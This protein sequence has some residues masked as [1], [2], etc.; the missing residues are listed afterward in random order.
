MELPRPFPEAFPAVGCDQQLAP[1]ALP[2][3]ESI[4][5][6]HRHPSCLTRLSYVQLPWKVFTAYNPFSLQ[7]LKVTG[8]SLS[9]ASHQ[10]GLCHKHVQEVGVLIALLFARP[11]QLGCC[12]V[13]FWLPGRAELLPQQEESAHTGTGLQKKPSLDFVTL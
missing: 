6:F 7:N 4:H 10:A 2:P 9:P 13:T 8:T 1:M 12:W 11:P 3:A 5:S